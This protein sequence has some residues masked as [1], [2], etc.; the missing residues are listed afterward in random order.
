MYFKIQVPV[1]NIRVRKDNITKKIKNIST[2][3][4]RNTCVSV[5]QNLFMST[6]RVFNFYEMKYFVFKFFMD[7]NQNCKMYFY[8]HKFENS[9]RI[10]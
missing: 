2:D 6:L 7:S 10:N 1:N 5:T 3:C 4:D 9:N 8:C